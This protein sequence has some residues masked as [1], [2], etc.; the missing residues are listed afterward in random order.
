MNKSKPT[1]SFLVAQYLEGAT[2]GAER[3]KRVV[4]LA[5]TS[6]NLDAEMIEKIARGERGHTEGDL[7]KDVEDDLGWAL[8]EAT[9]QSPRGIRRRG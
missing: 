9:H 4:Y 3:T 6:K 5:S 1:I 7:D 2:D 8:L